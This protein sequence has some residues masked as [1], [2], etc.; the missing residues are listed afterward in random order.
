[1]GK[2]KDY[3]TV[4]ITIEQAVKVIVGSSGDDE[5]TVIQALGNYIAFSE[6]FNLRYKKDIPVSPGEEPKEI[7]CYLGGAASGKHLF[8]VINNGWSGLVV[9]PKYCELIIKSTEGPEK[10]DKYTGKPIPFREFKANIT[11]FKELLNKNNI[12]IPDTW[13][14]IDGGLK[15]QDDNLQKFIDMDSLRW[16]E[17]KITIADKSIIM[18]SARGETVR[19]TS[20]AFGLI[21]KTKG[22]PN[23]IYLLFVAFANNQ[24]VDKSRKMTVSRARDLLRP[25]FG[26]QKPPIELSGKLYKPIFKISLGDYKNNKGEGRIVSLDSSGFMNSVPNPQGRDPQDELGDYRMGSG[27]D[28]EDEDDEAGEFIKNHPENK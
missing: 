17:V 12:P 24:P 9:D 18:I 20:G 15:K 16:D 2:L 19:V 14:N 23:E 4:D 22:T 13:V 10:Y 28:F 11:S 1:M 8:E 5:E 25:K 6:C 7:A 3:I 26:I 21:D 27:V